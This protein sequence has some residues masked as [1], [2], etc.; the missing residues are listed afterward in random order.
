MK[1]ISSSVTR[2]VGITSLVGLVAAAGCSSGSGSKFGS[3]DDAGGGSGGD[4]GGG[5]DSGIGFQT[6]DG[7]GSGDGGFATC[8]TAEATATRTPVYMLIVL[9]GSGSMDFDP[10]ESD[11][12]DTSNMRGTKWLAARGALYAF[13][14]Q[15][16]ATPDNSFGVGFYLF[17]SSVTHSPT[18]V[19]VGIKVVDAT[20][21]AALKARVK[22]PVYPSS[23]TPLKQSIEGQMALL[24]SF[25]PAAPLEAGGKLVLVVMTDGVPDGGSGDQTSCVNDATAGF[26]GTPQVTTFAVGVGN[27]T[28]STSDY[29]EVFMG[30]LA[31]AGGAPAAGCTPGWNQ[32][33]PAGQI[34]CHFQITPG[35]KTAA[36]IQA[37]F[38][39]AIDSIRDTVTS[40][41]FKL[42]KSGGT[43]NPSEVNVVYTA[44]DG[45]QVTIPQDPTNGWTY[46]NPTDPSTVTL[47][48]SS[49]STL[50]A[51]SKGTIKIV[52][53]C[54]TQTR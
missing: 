27:P 39:A 45:S 7:G 42:D 43:I 41:E 26:A 36:M 54:V 49:C 20:Q 22:P 25:T 17:S 2:F 21:N 40:C 34:P 13:W 28:A 12:L 10:Q 32:S 24:K 46:D 9:D 30:Q 29:D 23:G 14:D 44:G 31:V 16:V 33:S 37:E 52:L 50:K 48:G 47:E 18:A 5:G 4:G 8:A 53:G 3:G 35:T 1:S 6:G 51:D 38:L 15:L 19:D 11:P